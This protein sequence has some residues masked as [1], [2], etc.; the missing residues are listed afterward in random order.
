M[1]SYL[2]MKWLFLALLSLL[3][4]GC[5][6]NW[7][8]IPYSFRT[9]EIPAEPDY[10]KTDSWAAL[11]WVKDLADSL[12]DAS[13]QN[14]QERAD[15]DVFFIH[16]TTFWEKDARWNAGMDEEE[17]NA[18]TDKGPILH[19]A[20]V[21]NETCKV[22][23]PRYRQA[24]IKSYFHL[25]EGGYSALKIAY[26]DIRASFQYYLEHYNHGRPFYIASHS[27]GTTM[28]IM[29]IQEFIDGNDTLRELLV[30]AYLVGM[31][32]KESDFQHI[33]PCLEEGDLHCFMSWMTFTKN[34]Y[35][36]F[37]EE[38]YK[39]NVIT[40]PISFKL[41]SM[42]YSSKQDHGAI[43]NSKF[44]LKYR[45]TIAAKPQDGLLWI[46]KPDVPVLKW[47]I[48]TKNWHKADYNL[49]WLDIRKNVKHKANVYSSMVH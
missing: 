46:K 38:H 1:T 24:H 11:P 30:A 19:Q 8:Y 35:P 17:I 13:L 3:L 28:G 5:H 25:E 41:D 4:V 48:T 26:E 7:H 42:H 49:F 37:Y 36:W 14:N 31:P 15:F 2:I 45:H 33:P 29:L 47:F 21:F 22:Y 44:K 27:Q 6:Q 16:P 43:L 34:K 9:E 39:A 20:T 18:W 12:P 23:A 10:S 32:V 40:N